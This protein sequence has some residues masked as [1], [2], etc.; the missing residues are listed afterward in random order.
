MYGFQISENKNFKGINVYFNGEGEQTVG[1]DTL[2][3][4][5]FNV[6]IPVYYGCLFSF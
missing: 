3:I 5:A 4:L 6:V 1:L 2:L